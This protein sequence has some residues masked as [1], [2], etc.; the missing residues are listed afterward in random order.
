[1][2]CCVEIH[3]LYKIIHYVILNRGCQIFTQCQVFTF[4]LEKITSG[5]KNLC[6]LHKCACGACDKYEVWLGPLWMAA[7][8]LTCGRY[9][10]G[11][12]GPKCF[13]LDKSII[14]FTKL[15]HQILRFFNGKGETRRCQFL[16]R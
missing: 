11:A 6:K 13:A 5:R 16:I 15:I 7:Y 4:N 12:L 10:V 2:H 9:I 8:T 3:T 14:M 1:M